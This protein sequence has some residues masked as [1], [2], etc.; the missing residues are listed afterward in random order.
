MV[1]IVS[2]TDNNIN[3][4]TIG[5]LKTA[6]ENA[7]SNDR[8]FLDD[9]IYL[10]D[11]N[12]GIVIDKNLTIIGKSKGKVIIERQNEFGENDK[13]SINSDV[14]LR[15]VNIT[16]RNS[17]LS[18]GGTIF[19]EGNLSIINCNFAN[20]RVYGSGGVI[21]NK[22][23]L[24][25]SSS[26]FNN[27][28]A[29]DGGA[30]Y[31]DSG[32]SLKVFRCIFTNNTAEESGGAI[33]AAFKTNSF[34]VTGSTFT[35]NIAE[36]GA[37]IYNIISGMRIT[38]SRFKYNLDWYN[39]YRSIYSYKSYYKKNITLA[40]KEGIIAVDLRITKLTRKGSYQYIIIKNNGIRATNFKSW[41][42]K[43]Y[44]G[45]YVGKKLIKKVT[46]KTIGAKKFLKVKI[47]IP[48]KYR[49]RLK[50]FKVDIDHAIRESNKKN[51]KA[52]AR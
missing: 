36:K 4:S 21:F 1:G 33:F 20:N 41:G 34:T 48:K 35:I 13:F 6:V 24:N 3:N 32:S 37:A 7:N 2:A 18:Y 44:L 40:P 28:H 51:N 15:L 22:G 9:G 25:I 50:T 46:I 8:I 42:N 11:N 10:C 43:N 39:V 52:T 26:T 38:N 29:I 5:G 14:T 23:N 12:K 17:Q 19:N 27:N 45:V 30:I 31:S 16:I 47:F 49:N